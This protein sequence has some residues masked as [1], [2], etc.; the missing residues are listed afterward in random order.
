MRLHQYY[1]R[2]AYGNHLFSVYYSYFIDE[3]AI[4]VERSFDR[5]ATFRGRSAI[6]KYW[7]YQICGKQSNVSFRHVDSEMV[8]DADGPIAVVKW[9]AEFDNRRENRAEKA[10]KKVRFCQMAKLIFEE[11]PKSRDGSGSGTIPKMK[12]SYLE[13]YAQGMVGKSYQWPGIDATADELWEK[14]RFEPPKPP[15]PVACNRCGELFPSRTKLF[16]HIQYTDAQNES[17]GCC[18]C[19]PNEKAKEKMRMEHVLICLSVSYWCAD[20][21]KQLIRAWKDVSSKLNSG[22]AS[23]PTDDPVVVLTWAVPTE[24]SSS[25]IVNVVT[26]KLSRIPFEEIGIDLLP[27]VLNE[28][29]MSNVIPGI[30]PTENLSLLS[31]EDGAVDVVDEKRTMMVHTAGIVNRPCAPERRESEMYAAFIPWEFLDRQRKPQTNTTSGSRAVTCD[32]ACEGI[33]KGKCEQTVQHVARKLVYIPRNNNPNTKSCKPKMWHIPIEE[34]S[35]FEFVDSSIA[36]RLK[37]GARLMKDGGHGIDLE[38][39][40]DPSARKGPDT[41]VSLNQ[42][43]KVRTSAMEEPMHHYCKISISTR[44]MV[45]GYLER[46]VGLLFAFAR[47]EVCEDDFIAVL[48][49]RTMDVTI[50]MPGLRPYKIADFPSDFIVLIEPALTRYENK[51]KLKLCRYGKTNTNISESM[52]ASIDMAEEIIIGCIIKKESLLNQWIYG[53]CER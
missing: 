44:Q 52:E 38:S 51:T 20:P 33:K 27:K 6:E 23:K 50:D 14:I 43:L 10:H 32:N 4:Y 37:H 42:K 2:H 11:C 13:E 31:L 1:I 45:P 26:M 29:L 22:G 18:I 21:H 16:T 48:K 28:A 41:D 30:S 3:D 49:D 53:C 9:L 40:L 36:Q 34:T 8:R 46:L 39:N 35:A 24:L 25:A 12:I 5:K 47:F 17:D 7:R 15:P 19:V